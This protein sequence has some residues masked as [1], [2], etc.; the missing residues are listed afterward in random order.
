MPIQTLCTCGQSLTGKCQSDIKECEQ[1][2]LTVLDN[3]YNYE[4][5]EEK[6]YPIGGF[7]PGNYHQRCGACGRSF[8]GDKRA[9]QC[10]PCAIA[11]KEKFDALSPSEQGELMKRNAEAIN[12][13]FK[14]LGKPNKANSM[15]EIKYGQLWARHSELV[16]NSD[17]GN[18]RV[19][20][21]GLKNAVD[22][23]LRSAQRGAV[24]VK[25]SEFNKQQN[26]HYCGRT[27]SEAGIIYATIYWDHKWQRFVNGSINESVEF[28]I[29]DELGTAAAERGE[30]A[31]EFAQW[32]DS[33]ATRVSATQWKV[34]G[35]S[36]Q[37][38]A[39]T[40][41]LYEQ[42]KQKEK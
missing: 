38:I 31:V 8:F 32:I 10:E 3:H 1:L 26:I 29:L 33:I 2:F 39:T 23:A 20:F 12:E 11:D 9:Y 42:F 18:Y 41:A 16:N 21:E 27:K 19:S 17:V 14:D 7:A 36:I 5:M 30:D 13:A 28:E 25:V 15:S 4:D 24:W 22:E 40:G 6:K 35:G 37:S 34:G